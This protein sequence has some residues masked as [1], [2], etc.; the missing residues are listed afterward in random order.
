MKKIKLILAAAENGVIGNTQSPSGLPWRLPSEMQHFTKTTTG[1]EKNIVVIGRKTYMTFPPKYRP[2]PKRQNVILSTSL[3]QV[4]EGVLVF[5]SMQSIMEYLK[6]HRTDGFEDIFIAGGVQIYNLFL[7]V[8]DEIYLT[9]VHADVEGDILCPD[10][11]LEN[12][13]E[14]SSEYHPAD[15][16]NIYAFTCTRYIK[17]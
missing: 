3:A 5:N 8:A 16:K 12:W 2:L 1:N 17:K 14:A 13:A 11:H 4:E 9:T 15:E 10:L 6:S 7:P